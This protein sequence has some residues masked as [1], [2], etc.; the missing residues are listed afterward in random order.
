MTVN[1]C[2]VIPH[3]DHATPLASTLGKLAPYDLPVMIIDD[4]S[5]A[6]VVATLSSMTETM[7]N[8]SIVFLPQNGG[9]GS[10][11]IAGLREAWIRGYSHAVQVD[12]DGQHDLSFLGRM[13]Q[14]SRTHE[15]ALIATRPQYD[16][17]APFSRLVGRKLTNFMVAVETLGTSLPDVMCGFRVYP[18]KAMIPLLGVKHMGQRMDFDIEIMVRA[19]WEGLDI[20]YLTVPVIYPV[21]GVSHF[22]MFRDNVL[23]SLKHTQLVLGMLLRLPVLAREGSLW[24]KPVEVPVE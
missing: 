19:S 3:Y 21:R 8:V 11:V 2:V 22:R 4:G 9:K 10:A 16:E 12:A 15:Q 14:E 13:L 7:P 18:L 20:R 5:P 1:P 23:I 17:S 24:K 6:E